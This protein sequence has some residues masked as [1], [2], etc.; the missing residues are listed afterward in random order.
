M[1]GDRH[2]RD[3]VSSQAQRIV[4]ANNSRLGKD[5]IMKKIDFWYSVPDEDEAGYDTAIARHGT[6]RA[7]NLS[8]EP[9]EICI[10]ANGFGFH[11]IFGTQV[12]GHFLCIPD[13]GVGCELASYTDRFRNIESILRSGRIGRNEAYAIGNALDLLSFM[14]GKV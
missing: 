2:E 3:P 4:T 9:Y 5:D 11:T 13:W 1:S 10:N 6:I 12:N 7:I 8:C 14:V